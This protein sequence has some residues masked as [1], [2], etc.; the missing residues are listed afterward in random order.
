[1]IITALLLVV[2]GR[3]CDHPCTGPC[4]DAGRHGL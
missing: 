1:M 3:L 4:C 2:A